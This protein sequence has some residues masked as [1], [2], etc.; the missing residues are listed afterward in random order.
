MNPSRAPA[1]GRHLAHR[2]GLVL[3]LSIVAS[4]ALGCIRFDLSIVVNDDGSGVLGYNIAVND[5]LLTFGGSEGFGLQ[6]EL[7]LEGEDLPPGTEVSEYREDGYSGF[8]ITVPFADYAEIRDA[9]QPGLDDA[10]VVEMPDIS[11]DE[12][13]TWHFSM[14]VPPLGE[15]DAED[16]QL[17]KALLIDG[18]FRVRVTLPGEIE[19]HNADRLEDEEL[20][21]EL[22]FFAT[23]PR[24]LT[25]SAI[26]S[27]GFPLAVI[28]VP[29]AVVAM[30]ILVAVA[31]L[32]LTKRRPA[33]EEEIDG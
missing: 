1:N 19:E 29:A 25:A 22:D 31:A 8:S 32:T 6:E 7:P 5:A 28:G 14:R 30:I 27:G 33:T 9:L 3:L 16:L 2:V 15:E 18:W 23:E 20:F 21:W 4:A 11:Q 17:A 13:G 26:P 12:D 10:G 24:L